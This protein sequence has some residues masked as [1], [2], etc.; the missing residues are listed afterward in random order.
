M[1]ITPTLR[2]MK[3]TALFLTVL[4]VNVMARTEAQTFSYEGKHVPLKT[5][6]V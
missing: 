4:A 1:T 3:L 2:I 5:V 6:F